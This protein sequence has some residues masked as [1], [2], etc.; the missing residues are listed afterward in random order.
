LAALD[1]LDGLGWS[2]IHARTAELHRAA[3][4]ALAAVSG[5]SVA[6]PPPPQAG[7]LAFT[8]RG[9]DPEQASRALASRGVIVRPIPWPPALRASVGFYN[10]ERDLA[11]LAEAV[12]RVIG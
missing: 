7:L 12:E 6:T 4:S 3:R 5:V 1:W 9:R 10:D 2:A 11:R 8:M